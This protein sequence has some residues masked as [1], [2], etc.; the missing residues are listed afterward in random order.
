MDKV[1]ISGI[2]PVAHSVTLLWKGI[3]WLRRFPVFPMATLLLVLVIPSVFADYVAPY[4]P[5]K[6]NV[7]DRLQPPAWTG[8][9]VVNG[10]VVAKAGTRAHILG[11]DKIGRDMLSRIIHGARVSLIVA[12]I[13]ITAGALVGTT[14]GLLAGYFGGAWDNVIMRVVDVKLSIP[15]ILLA[16]SL[17]HI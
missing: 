16:L 17:I 11:T 13:A 7:L 1:S 2:T 10:V 14:L 15:A 6:G 9:R 3:V 8:E 12:L 4:D 5:K